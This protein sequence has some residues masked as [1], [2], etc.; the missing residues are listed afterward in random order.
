MVTTVDIL[1][2]YMKYTFHVTWKW[3]NLIVSVPYL[4]TAT[5]TLK[6]FFAL[7]SSQIYPTIIL[8]VTGASVHSPTHKNSLYRQKIR[9]YIY[10]IR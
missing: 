6:L 5:V 3:N 7:L 4:G 9:W 1:P 10:N 2:M 8:C